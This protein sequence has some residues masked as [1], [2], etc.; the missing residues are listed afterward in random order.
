[1]N[2]TKLSD[3]ENFFHSDLAHDLRGISLCVH[4]ALKGGHP[5]KV[6]AE[7]VTWLLEK[8]QIPYLRQPQYTIAYKGKQVGKYYPDIMLAAGKVLVDF[9]VVHQIEARHRAQVLS[10]LAVTGAELGFILNFDADMLQMER[11]P[12]FLEKHK[13]LVWQPTIP[14]DILFPE[15]TNRVVE[16]LY[17]VHH[18]LGPG[19]LPPIYRRALGVELALQEIAYIYLKEL[20]L[21]FQPQSIAPRT[22]R[23]FFIKE[24]LLLATLAA[25]DITAQHAKKMRWTM[26][27]MGCQL[28]IIANFYPGRLDIHFFR[29]G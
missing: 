5:K 17:I 27:K 16:A 19:F 8:K 1:M 7:A 12:N 14:R 10:H 11:L 18:E 4:S 6:Y 9:K 28:G 21:R 3:Q 24:K 2:Q 29:Q 23:L 20:P 15:L 25:S 13:P 26:Q 22:D